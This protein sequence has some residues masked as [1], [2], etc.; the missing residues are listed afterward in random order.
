MK[1][2]TDEWL[3][4][5]K[6]MITGS[7]VAAILGHSK[8]TSREALMKE[9]IMEHQGIEV[10]RETNQAMEYGTAN[11]PIARKDFET[12]H[13]V[14]V[15]EHAFFQ[16]EE[17]HYIG[18]SPDGV[19]YDEEKKMEV[20][21]EIKCPFYG[22]IPEKVPDYYFDQVQL[23]MEV[24]DLETC[25]FYY[26]TP[27]LAV[28]F[29]IDRDREWFK[30]AMTYIGDF[31]YEFERRKNDPLHEVIE[32]ATAI[33]LGNELRRIRSEINILK[34]TDAAI[35]KNLLEYTTVGVDALIGNTEVKT[36]IRK[37]AV[38]NSK[39]AEEFH[40]DLEKYRKKPSAFQKITFKKGK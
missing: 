21:L 24:M 10:P 11:E 2:G 19:Y 25:A 12:E 33:E 29:W 1:Q 26:W 6:G 8:W 27:E 36:V 35:T 15:Q 37:G 13:N 28:V 4:A 30:S 34:A 40:I 38:D 17:Y 9:F 39:I 22:K 31:I 3:E 5:R 18:C 20:L 23:C 14:E 16:H 7:K 32:D